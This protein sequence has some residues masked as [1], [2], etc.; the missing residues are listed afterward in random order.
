[1]G[2]EGSASSGPGAAVRGTLR[3]DRWTQMVLAAFAVTVALYLLPILSDA[4]RA[5]LTRAVGPLTFLGLIVAALLSGLGRLPADERRFWQDVAA[6]FVALLAAAALYLIYP[7]VEKPLA[8]D[9]TVEALYAAYYAALVLAAERQPHR[10]YRWRPTGLER[11]LA[12]PAVLAFVVALF[13]YFTVIPILGG[14][15]EPRRWASSYALYL[16]L[17]VYLT[18][19][20]LW[21]SRSART[22]RWRTLYLI[23]GLTT[24]AV[25]LT[26]LLELSL[27][28]ESPMMWGA[29]LDIVYYLPYLAIILARCRHF[30]F[31][32]ENASAL[33]EE[34]PETHYT[35]PSG[36]TMVHALGFPL[37]HLGGYRFGLFD[38]SFRSGREVLVLGAV[39]VLGSIAVIQHRVLEKKARELWRDREA[40][41]ATLRRN[42]KD[43]R[44]MVER[45][46]TDQR[47]RLSEEKLAKAFRAS[48]DAMMITSL[49]DGLIKEVN[50]S[51]EQSTGYCR[52]D[53]LGR[54][55]GEFRLWDDP[56]QRQE[57]VRSLER[58]GSIRDLEV[59]F[60]IR[61][62][63]I[64]TGLVS[65]E[66]LNIDGEPHLLSVTR[67]ITERK[68]IE[69]KLKTQ[70]VLLD[71]AQDAIAVLDLED[72]VTYWNR[73]S[74]R[75]Y[76]WSAAEALGRPAGELLRGKTGQPL[77]ASKRVDEKGDW[78]GELRPVT[79]D[80]REI[81]VESWWTLMRDSDGNPQSKLI[82]STAAGH[83]TDVVPA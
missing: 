69:E 55:V 57:M 58:R 8:L 19:R 66:K 15:P 1:M 35:R 37:L 45:Y 65:I 6:A 9:L 50:D 68:R 24:C 12:W 18:V 61:S 3:S 27:Y 60:R 38:P 48:P 72:R 36:R 25:F 54:S 71:K 42:E 26:D 78:T 73:S 16:A 4:Q 46:H 83:K 21:L 13:G 62:G 44:V 80:G 20:F 51:F 22:M 31:G 74:E 10:T 39:L 30:P 82:I 59:R 40:V 47:L 76:G 32:G 70:A 11:N 17:D 29:D 33:A 41:E 14:S 77:E 53:V 64:R 75:L 43:L 52:E 67:D 23:L 34:R 28:L 5:L 79:K 81:V 63:Q 49:L 56:E 2:L 7:R